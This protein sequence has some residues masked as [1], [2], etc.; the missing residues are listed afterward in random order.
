MTDGQ[1][2][3]DLGHLRDRVAALEASAPGGSSGAP[4]PRRPLRAFWSAVLLTLA[5]ILAPLSVLAVW[6]ADVVGNTDRYVAAVAPLASDPA[7]QDAVADGVT[8]ALMSRLDLAMLVDQAA[9]ADRPRLSALLQQLT[10][11]VENVLAGFVHD[12]ALAVVQSAAFA[13]A[14]VDANRLAHASVVSALTGNQ[15]GLLR[16][17]GDSVVI[18]LAP[19]ID[20][21]KQQLVDAGLTVVARI[22]Q[23]H[24]EF[25]IAQSQDVSRAK[26]WF[27]LLQYAGD[28]LPVIGAVLAAGGVLLAAR[29]RRALIALALGVAGATLVLQ[30]GLSVF[31]SFYL[32][33]LTTAVSPAAAGAVY[34]ALI[35]FLRN[36]ARTVIVLGIVVALAAWV[37][38]GGQR[39]RAAR[40]L[41][42]SALGG[43]RSGAQRLGLRL[44][45]VGRFAH[46]FKP[47]IAWFLVGAAALALAL[48]S[49]PTGWVIYW[50][51]FGLLCALALLEFLDDPGSPVEPPGSAPP[52]AQAARSVP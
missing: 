30:I 1:A 15:S 18:D 25:T 38:G 44:G 52:Q 22:P 7:V 4:A 16:I 29:R 17:T 5:C 41:W 10:R 49:Y 51:A 23:I 36:S 27:R 39:A 13:T 14:W 32:G 37:S 50:L 12:R 3:E 20:Q 9:P 42:R 2:G 35:R 8:T 34:D 33:D 47:A 24:A 26:T 21:V 31:R 6:A 28:W 45:P 19:V 46:R 11:P 40:A 48:W 43:L